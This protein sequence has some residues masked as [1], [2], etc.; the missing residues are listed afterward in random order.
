MRNCA[1]RACDSGV[2]SNLVLEMLCHC[3]RGGGGG[4]SECRA[5]VS[6]V[7]ERACFRVSARWCVLLV[8]EE[9]GHVSDDTCAHPVVEAS[10]VVGD[11]MMRKMTMQLRHRHMCFLPLL[12]IALPL[13]HWHSLVT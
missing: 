12:L 11:T 9:S 3:S 4:G 6:R 2:E 13:A 1:R 10:V 5:Q 7:N 8:I